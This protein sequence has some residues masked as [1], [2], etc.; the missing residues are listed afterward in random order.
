MIPPP[1]R[2]LIQHLAEQGMPLRQ[3]SRLLHLSRNTLR[4]ILR[5][6][7]PPAPPAPEPP[8]DADTLAQ[9]RAA[10][11][12]CRGNVVRVQEVLAAEHGLALPYSTLTRRVRAAGLRAPPRRV[13]E[14]PLAPGEEMQHDTS[15][16][17]VPL[18]GHT[19]LAQCIALAL[20]YSRRRC[21]ARPA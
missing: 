6:P 7:H 15:P 11:T 20:G 9:V 3:M 17:R 5:D 13:G 18:A 4:R 19:V 1:T 10:Y 8:C 14:Y 12:R 16:H 21:C 2:E